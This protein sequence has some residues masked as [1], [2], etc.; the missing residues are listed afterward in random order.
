MGKIFRDS[1]PELRGL[2]EGKRSAQ[3]TARQRET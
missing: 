1:W 3:E 2:R